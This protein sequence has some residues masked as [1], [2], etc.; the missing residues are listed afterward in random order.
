MDQFQLVCPCV[1]GVEGLVAEELRDMGAQ[2]VEPQNGRVVFAGSEEML[3]RANLCSRYSERVLVLLGTF[4]A[5]TFEQLF[6]GV[7]ALPWEQW[8]GKLDKFPVKG[9]SLSSQLSSVPDCQ[10]IIKKAIVERLKLKYRIPWFEESG[11]MYQVQFLILKDTVS[12]MLD[13]SGVGLH[14]RG[15]RPNAAEAPIKETLAASMAKLARLWPDS[16]VYDPFCGS[17]TILIES[18]LLAM[19]IAPGLQRRFAAQSWKG[20]DES[21]WVRERER[22]Q[23][24]VRRD[25]TFL[26][27]G[28]DI[29]G[30]AVALT[31]EN[32]KKA[33][34]IAH[35][36][37]EK[38]DIRDFAEEGERGCVICNPPYGE[39][40]LDLGQAEELY[41]AMGQR[42]V[43]KRGWSYHIISPDET[44]E[45]CFGRPA[46]KRRKLYNG[47]IKC[48][49]YSY[50]KA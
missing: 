39:R 21:V 26:A 36:R 46:D 45:S 25:S 16:H 15:Y 5:V 20:V 3:A 8:I 37:A 42:F 11:D 43:P 18:A 13:T 35:I 4:R 9:R 28:Y 31:L 1:L 6:Q 19:N 44:F 47:M 22:A 17:G 32:A 24:L 10:S 40:L 23:D 29:D 34:V 49:L 12:V 7:K 50:F 33:G 41:T 38:R 2:Q 30:A 27:T 48:Q 14:K